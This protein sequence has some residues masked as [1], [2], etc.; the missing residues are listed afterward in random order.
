MV[1]LKFNLLNI[2]FFHFKM[3]EPEDAKNLLEM[4][5]V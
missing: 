2:L 5:Y 1:N 3:E 4:K